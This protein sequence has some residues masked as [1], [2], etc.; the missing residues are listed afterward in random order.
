MYLSKSKTGYHLHGIRLDATQ[1]TGEN[2]SKTDSKNSRIV[3]SPCRYRAVRM[4]T[5]EIHFSVTNFFAV[6]ALSLVV[7]LSLSLS[8]KRTHV[9]VA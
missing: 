8:E 1:T 9:N 2:R 5:P 4:C 3:L 6:A 7:A